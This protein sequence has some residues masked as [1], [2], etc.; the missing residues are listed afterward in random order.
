[1]EEFETRDWEAKILKLPG[2]EYKDV[3]PPREEIENIIK[4]SL[5]RRGVKNGRIVERN[6]TIILQAFGTLLRKKGK[7][8]VNIRKVNKPIKISTKEI[9]KESLAIGNLRHG[10]TV[11]YT[12]NYQKESDE[13]TVNILSEYL[14]DEERL[15]SAS[16]EINFYD[17]KTPIN[18]VFTKGMPERKF[19][20]DLCKQKNSQKID[21][22]I[23][24]RDQGFYSIEYS[25][26]KGEHPIQNTF[27]PD[28]FIKIRHN[29]VIVEIKVDGDDSEENK[30]KLKW[31]KEY[32]NDLNG[33]L[34]R[35]GLETKYFFHFLSP[36]SFSEFFEYLSDG[37]LFKG[38]FRSHLEDLLEQG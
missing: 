33:E 37:R 27:N 31:S 8:V 25:W 4:E 13:E 15:V 38:E 23:K 34:K 22:W 17:F 1:M 16:K 11:F 3:I 5:K 21:A 28:F 19:V 18:L 2:G 7:T 12:E 10:A 6:H 20:E 26:R 32:V 30:A 36:A 29:V 9:D 35:Q 14:S 24:S